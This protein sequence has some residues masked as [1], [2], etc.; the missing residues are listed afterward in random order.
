M[1]DNNDRMIRL[2]SLASGDAYI[3]NAGHQPSSHI[4][5]LMQNKK[6]SC[7]KHSSEILLLF[8]LYMYMKCLLTTAVISDA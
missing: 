4:R 8:A 7:K 2:V 5:T 1:Y 3:D 6:Y